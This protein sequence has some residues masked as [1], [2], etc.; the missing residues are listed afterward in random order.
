MLLA[1]TASRLEIPLSFCAFP[2]TP[3]PAPPPPKKKKKKKKSNNKKVEKEPNPLHLD[4]GAIH[5]FHGMYSHVNLAA[6]VLFYFVHL[7]DTELFSPG[8]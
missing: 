5:H 8:W 1:L 6:V 2:C 7:P 4:Q 3:H